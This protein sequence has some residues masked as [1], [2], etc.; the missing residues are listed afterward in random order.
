MELDEPFEEPDAGPDNYMLEAL[1]RLGFQRCSEGNLLPP[2][3][4]ELHAFQTATLRVFNPGDLEAL[5]AMS[6]AYLEGVS[7]GEQ[8]LG[9]AP[10]QPMDDELFEIE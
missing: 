3:W 2:S 5:R 1:M 4:Q 8:P 6:F 7:V 10:M 9:R